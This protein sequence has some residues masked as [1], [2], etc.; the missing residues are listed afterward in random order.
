ML[1]PAGSVPNIFAGIGSAMRFA[2]GV[3]SC[4]QC[5]RFFVIHRHATKRLAD[6]TRCRNRI[7]F[8]VR[9]FRIYIDQSHLNRAKRILQFADSLHSVLS[10]S[11]VVSE[12]QYTSSLR[13]PYIFASATKTKGLETHRLEGTVAGEDHQVS[14]GNFVAV[15]LFDRPKQTR[16]LSRFALS[17]QLLRGAKRCVLRLRHHGHPQRDRYPAL[18]HAI[19][20][21]NG[22]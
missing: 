22:P 14:P 4:N 20:M 2:K 11:H 16:A 9:T 3:S 18:C 15:F 5:H 6:V 21:K 7:R 19:R 13:F 1:A 8:S 12:P 10:P 17:G